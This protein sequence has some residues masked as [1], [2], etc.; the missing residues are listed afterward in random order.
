MYTNIEGDRS[1]LVQ[2]AWALLSF[3]DAGQVSPNIYAQS[4]MFFLVIERHVSL[5]RGVEIMKV[6]LTGCK[7][8]CTNSLWHEVL[9]QF[10][11][12]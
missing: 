6:G 11:D 12:G 10:T 4:C 3:I 7:R 8:P 2:T 5:K 1:N 9:D